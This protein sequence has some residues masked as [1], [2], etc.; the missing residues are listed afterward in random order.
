[1]KPILAL[2]V[3][4][5]LIA[6]GCAPAI[7]AKDDFATSALVAKGEIPPEFAE[8]NRSDPRINARLSRQLCATPYTRLEE[9]SLGAEPGRLAAWR[10]RCETHVPIIG[11][12][13]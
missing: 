12:W 3:L 10:G 4:V 6:A 2:A 9:K 11:S 1:M 13:D 8:F 7:P 5:P